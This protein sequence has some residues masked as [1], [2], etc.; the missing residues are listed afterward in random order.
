MTLELIGARLGY[1]EKEVL[2]QVDFSLAQGE[3]VGLIGPNGAGKS[4]LLKS[5][6]GILP[7]GRG[8]AQV[9]GRE[10]RQLSQQQLARK[11]AYLPQDGQLAFG[12]TA[13][14]VVLTGC[15]PYLSWLAQEGEAER[16]QARRCLALMGAEELTAQPVDQ[17]SGGQRQ[18][19]LLARTLL[20]QAPYWVLDEPLGELDLAAGEQLLQLCRQLVEKGLGILLSLHDLTLAA[21]Y[22]DRLVL[23]GRGK[24]LAQGTP[25]QVLTETLLSEAYGLSCQVVR[26]PGGLRI[27]PRPNP[28]Q[29]KRQQELL[30]DILK[31]RF[32]EAD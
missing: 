23:V 3:C 16:Q 19:V 20:Q 17:L 31:N 8:T 15:Y 14:D 27:Q 25:E 10:L 12:Y 24:I 18:R 2:D 7:L 32:T 22:C 6:A 26:G 13:E 9:D 5:L 30:Q 11:I 21:A 28:Q 4:T 1:R 29:E